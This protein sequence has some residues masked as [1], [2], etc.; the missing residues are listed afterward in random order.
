MATCP[1]CGASI[2]RLDMID[3]KCPTCAAT[4]KR[5][6]SEEV[7]VKAEQTEALASAARKIL[8]S[9]ETAPLGAMITKRLGLV[10]A[11]CAFGMNLLKDAMTEFRDIIGGRAGALEKTLAD[12]RE[13]SLQVL[14]ERAVQMGANA[15][16]AIDIDISEF[17]RS[18]ILVLATGTAVILETNNSDETENPHQV[19]P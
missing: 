3:G 18:A 5:A 17:G 14:R 11:E 19:D 13:T 7:A 16:I 9:T 8:L 12:A 4:A 1:S 6:K 10:S 2:W 15:V